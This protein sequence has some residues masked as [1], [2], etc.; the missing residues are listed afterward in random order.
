LKR[1]Q[2]LI[3]RQQMVDSHRKVNRSLYS[4]RQ[5]AWTSILTNFLLPLGD[6]AFGQ[7]LMKRLRFLEEAQWWDPEQLAACRNEALERLV[8]VAYAE[9]PFYRDLMDGAGLRPDEIRT[10]EDLSRLPIVTKQALRQGYPSRVTRATGQRTFESCTSGSTGTN[11][12]LSQDNFTVGWYRAPFLLALGWA[13]WQLGERHV[14]MGMTHSR[15]FQ[16]RLK[17]LMLGCYYVPANDLADASLDRTLELMQDQ[18]IRHLWGYPGSLYFLARRAHQKGWN[19]PVTS[20]VTWGDNLYPHYRSMIENAFKARVHDTYGC[21]EGIQ[22]SA[23]CGIGNTYHVHTLDTIL[24]LVDEAGNPVAPGEPANVVLTRLHPGPMPLIRYRVGDVARA[25]GLERCPC[26]RGFQ[27][28]DGI[29]GRDTD[30]VITPTGKPLIVHFFTGV[31]EHF[32][33]IDAFQVLQ[34]RP[35][36]MLLRIK[37]TPHYAPDTAV[38]IKQRLQQM[39]AEDIGI[40]IELCMEIPLT[41][42]GKR[43]FIISTLGRDNHVR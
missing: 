29:Q 42:G 40:E 31:L 2:R 36:V 33:E 13:G 12:R 35:D 25:G 7:P 22:V 41:P 32:P 39:G 28:M 1:Q 17:D 23:Q 16:K 5:G 6:F 30:V 27:T 14:Q 15:S 26:G 21:A 3:N 34:E 4:L 19:C 38:R 24:E 11:F 9:V 20:I 37:P 8:K 18:H 43:R 10:P